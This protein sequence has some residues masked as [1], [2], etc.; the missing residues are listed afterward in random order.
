MAGES[1]AWLAGAVG[2]S[3]VAALDAPSINVWASDAVWIAALAVAGRLGVAWIQTR[4]QS[5]RAVSSFA[6]ARRLIRERGRRR[7]LDVGRNLQGGPR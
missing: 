1:A 7:R 2:L 6:W 3:A 4:R 5:P